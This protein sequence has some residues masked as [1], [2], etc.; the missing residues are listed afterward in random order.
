MLL[1]VVI[2]GA[3]S[4]T[5]A[6]G[7]GSPVAS[8]SVAPPTTPATPTPVP[9]HVPAIEAF[10][11]RVTSGSMSYRIAYTGKVK[12]S[13]DVVPIKGSMAVS[14]ADFAA[15]FT[16]DFSQEDEDVGA[17][18][19]QV[20]GV[21]DKAWTRRDKGAW[22][23]MKGYDIADSY[24]PFKA[25]GSTA[26]IKFLGSTEV[27]GE[28]MYRIAV[29]G[30][31]LIHP[32]TIPYEIKKEKVD[33]TTL[34]VLIDDVGR[35]RRGTWNLRGQ[36]RVGAGIGQL[37]RIVYDLDLEFAKVGEPLTIDRP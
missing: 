1:G 5:G 24:V 34:E 17:T 18:R 19:V 8:A 7:S 16:Y 14:G 31:L 22:K 3:C 37:Q 32:N 2:L 35:P 26:D 12:A 9:A 23:A 33:Q 4:Q 6:P 29:P 25:V 10:V 11:E 20:R 36:A 30:A 21:R 15:S 27:E 28:V 13:V